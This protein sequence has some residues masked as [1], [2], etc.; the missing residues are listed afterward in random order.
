MDPKLFDAIRRNDIT[1]F[2]SLVKEDEEILNQITQDSFSTPLHLATKYGCTEMVSEIVRLFPDMVFA[3]NKQ[4][5]TP[6]HEACQQENVKV[7]MLLLEAN[8]TA[9]C[10]L[11]SSCKSAFMV[12]CSHGHLDMVNLLLNLSEMV[13]LEVAGFDE[14]CI[15]IAIS[16]GHTGRHESFLQV[17]V[18]CI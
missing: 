15:H 12:A 1:T 11:N 14:A 4:L 10:K 18:N 5:K 13:G 7:L 16:R 9:A 8:P 6:I 2:S 17:F 3:E